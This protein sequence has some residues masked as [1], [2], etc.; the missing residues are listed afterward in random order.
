MRPGRTRASRLVARVEA[1]IYLDT[2]V[3]AWLSAG[4]VDLLSK[5]AKKMIDKDGELLVSPMV[6]LEL[7]YLH[8]VGRL[9]VGGQA[10]VHGLGM[11]IGL[12]I[13]RLPFSD[14]LE[15]ALDQAWTRDPF[16]RLIVAHALAAGGTLLTKDATIRRRCKRAQW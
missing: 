13:C 8:E 2:H 7:E 10:I 16:D 14:L 1:V 11:Q 6:V 12:Q 4:R 9:G 3:V 5:R 15:A